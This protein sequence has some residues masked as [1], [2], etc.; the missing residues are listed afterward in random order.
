MSWQRQRGVHWSYGLPT[1]A[2]GGDIGFAR[3]RALTTPWTDKAI[4]NRETFLSVEQA[5]GP[6]W[7]ARLNLLRQEFDEDTLSFVVAGGVNRATRSFAFADASFQRT[8]NHADSVDLNLAGAFEAWGRR[9]QL[10]AGVD[11]RRSEAK[12]LGY[13]TSIATYPG[14]A[15]LD[16]DL[17]GFARPTV[18]GPRNGWPAYGSTQKG[19]Y[20]KLQ[21]QATDA[22]RLIVGGRYGSYLHDE[23]YYTYDLGGAVTSFSEFRYRD[24]DVFTPYAGLVHALSPE[25]NAYASVT[26][27]YKPQSS[28]QQ[29]PPESP[30]PLDPIRGRNTELGVKGALFDGALDASLALYRIVR[31]GEAA[32][33]PAYPY[34]PGELG[35]SCCYFAQGRLVSQGVDTELSGE[36]APGWQLFAGYT[37][38][39]NQNKQTRQTFHAITPR[40]MLKLWSTVGLRGGLSAWTL[41]GGVTLQSRQANTGLDWVYDADTGWSQAPFAIRQGGYAL[42]SASAKVQ[43]NPDWSLALNLGNLLDKQYYQTL[44]TPRGGNWYGEPRSAALTLRGRF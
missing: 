14:G 42:W 19:V 18:L 5:L 4:T 21:L 31:T 32:T 13:T 3:D 29:G 43:L 15:T 35:S 12:Q 39:Q 23:P 6:D 17:N 20:A 10:V 40:H 24:R 22:L 1:Y 8:G 38:N 26:E 44:G 36:L 30:T 34:T 2:D 33:D 7:T 25:W 27:I 28:Y 37:W 11:W 16:T 9:H 41:G